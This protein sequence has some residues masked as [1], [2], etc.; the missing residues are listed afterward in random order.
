MLPF[1][2]LGRIGWKKLWAKAKQVNDNEL[3]EKLKDCSI[4]TVKLNQKF[5]LLRCHCVYGFDRKLSMQF[6]P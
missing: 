4:E 5:E 2:M 3:N 6:D 1:S